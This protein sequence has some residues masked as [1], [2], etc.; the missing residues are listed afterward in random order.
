MI[1][2]RFVRKDSQDFLVLDGLD[3]GVVVFLMNLLVNGGCY[4]FMS[5]RLDVLLGDCL[6]NIFI[7]GGFVLS[8]VRHE[9]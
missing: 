2:L 7:D 3:G 8:I 5:L 1:G 9:A 4:V 6:S